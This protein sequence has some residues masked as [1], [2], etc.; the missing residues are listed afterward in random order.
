METKVVGKKKKNH[1]E[2]FRSRNIQ[3]PNIIFGFNVLFVPK[4]GFTNYNFTLL[5]FIY[6]FI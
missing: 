4:T 5:D 1:T 2:K 6:L 3:T